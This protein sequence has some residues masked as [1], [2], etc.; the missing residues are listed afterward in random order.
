[1]H[2]A[3]IAGRQLAPIETLAPSIIVSTASVIPHQR[4]NSKLFLISTR[5]ARYIY[6]PP[7]CA[8]MLKNCSPRLL[9]PL[10]YWSQ[11]RAAL[12]HYLNE[13]LVGACGSARVL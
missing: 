10:S 6:C 12:P 9:I 1:M 2:N 5:T 4:L 8:G 13:V 11:S 7:T 3:A